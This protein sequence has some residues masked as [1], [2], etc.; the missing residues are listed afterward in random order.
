MNATNDGDESSVNIDLNGSGDLRG[1]GQAG[2][3][4]VNA[5]LVGADPV[6]AGQAD[7]DIVGAGPDGMNAAG[8]NRRAFG[9]HMAG[10]A[11]GLAAG[12]I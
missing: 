8:W 11:A 4:L 5:D 9:R 6:N 1:A 10:W 7:A 12:W 2:A 3:D